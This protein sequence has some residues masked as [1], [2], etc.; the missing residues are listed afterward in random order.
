VSA[1]LLAAA[2]GRVKESGSASNVVP[3]PLGTGAVSADKSRKGDVCDKAKLSGPALPLKKEGRG[4]DASAI[5]SQMQAQGNC[6]LVGSSKILTSAPAVCLGGISP[7]QYAAASS[8]SNASSNN[9]LESAATSQHRVQHVARRK[10]KEEAVGANDSPFISPHCA[11]T[12]DVVDDTL[13]DSSIASPVEG[14]SP[15]EV[16]SPRASDAGLTGVAAGA[17]ALLKGI[18]PI[19]FE[20]GSQT[21]AALSESAP[22]G[23]DGGRHECAAPGDSALAPLLVATSRESGASEMDPNVANGGVDSSS[24]ALRGAQGVASDTV[25]SFART[26]V[27]LGWGLGRPMSADCLAFEREKF[28]F[29]K[30]VRVFVGLWPSYPCSHSTSTEVARLHT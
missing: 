13:P 23:A 30:R 28:E 12:G 26:G 5:A 11:W 25:K 1:G 15:D 24:I 7:S 29:F 9:A 22:D 21:G 16:K 2:D 4:S 20:C 6:G 19:D 8:S 14:R 3:P 10:E 17:R 27:S 18:S